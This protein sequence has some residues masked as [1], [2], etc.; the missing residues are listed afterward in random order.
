[1][2]TVLI[3]KRGTVVIPAKLRKRYR[4]DEGS[5]MLIEE[6]ED[7]ILMRPAATTPIDFEIYTPE[8]LAEFFL[9]NVMTKEGYL[10][11]RKDVEQ[12][13]IN[14]DSIDHIRWPA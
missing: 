7:G 12:M 4:L 2:Q 5:P 9:N 8:R 14:P 1:M 6:R 3:G 13:G 10:E 11:A